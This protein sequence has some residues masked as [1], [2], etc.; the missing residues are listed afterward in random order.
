[1]PIL[2]ELKKK[3]AFEEE[4]PSSKQRG[5]AKENDKRRS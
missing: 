5:S 4:Q 3:M 1:L 2:K